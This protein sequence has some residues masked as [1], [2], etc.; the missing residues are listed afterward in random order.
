MKFAPLH[1]YSSFS[2]LQSGLTIQK[3]VNA[4]KVNDYFG[5]A[6]CDKEVMY[7]VPNFALECEKEKKPYLIGMETKIND[8]FVCL[9]SINE[10][11]YLNLSFITSAIGWSL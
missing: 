9:Y 7:G 5:V 1:V 6:I 4:T 3:I 11:G 2:F 8:T 10:T